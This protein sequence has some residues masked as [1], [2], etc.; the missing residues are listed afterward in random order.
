MAHA[1]SDQPR[2]A[3]RFA[4][5]TNPRNVALIVRCTVEERERWQVCAAED[6]IGLSE[7]IRN[8]LDDV[9]PAD[10]G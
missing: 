9:Y 8:L 1:V 10:P 7:A 3:G 5:V 2:K 4:A 6:G